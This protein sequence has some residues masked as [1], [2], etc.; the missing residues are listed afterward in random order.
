MP[1]NRWGK[2]IICLVSPYVTGVLSSSLSMASL[3][4]WYPA[5]VKPWFNPPGWIFAPVWTILYLMMGV[6]LFLVWNVPQDRMAVFARY[7][8]WVHLFFNG[9]WTVLFFGLRSPFWAFMGIIILWGM[10]GFMICIFMRI[11]RW[12]ALLL[13]PYWIWVSF[14]GFL[15][16]KI[17]QLN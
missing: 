15:N 10:I 17:W 2:L 16:F 13:V 5:L 3:Q 1:I 4:S 12:A 11:S 6:S 8:F 9:L 7:L 14:A